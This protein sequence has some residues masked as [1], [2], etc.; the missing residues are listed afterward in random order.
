MASWTR[1][2][3]PS[4]TQP[5]M[6][7]T[8]VCPGATGA[9]PSLTVRSPEPAPLLAE[10]VEVRHVEPDDLSVAGEEAHRSR[11]RA[12][13]GQGGPQDAQGPVGDDLGARRLEE[14]APVRARSLRR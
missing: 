1:R 9:G 6:S 5:D 12:R 4:P 2:P 7:S 14:R 11:A 13:G 8:I 10:E 3:S